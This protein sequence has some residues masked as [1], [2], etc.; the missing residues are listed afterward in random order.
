M[1]ISLTSSNEGTT[2][3]GESV[4]VRN[5][6]FHRKYNLGVY[7][8]YI[9]VIEVFNIIKLPIGQCICQT[10]LFEQEIDNENY[11]EIGFV[12]PRHN[13]ATAEGFLSS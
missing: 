3:K 1:I 11:Q 10:I 12:E 6:Q 5:L 13:M 2:C 4:W 7:R 9:W 8:P